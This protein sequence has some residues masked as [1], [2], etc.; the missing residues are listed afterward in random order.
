M[1]IVFTQARVTKGKNVCALPCAILYEAQLCAGKYEDVA[2]MIPSKPVFAKLSR[3]RQECE[4]PQHGRS[5]HSLTQ[6]RIPYLAAA[7]HWP[8]RRL[9]AL[10]RLVW[11]R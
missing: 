8:R 2:T 11:L 3:A 6:R 1:E 5:G 7:H 9:A 4:A 10:A